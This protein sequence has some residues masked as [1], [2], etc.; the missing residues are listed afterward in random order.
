MI[1]LL[2]LRV[3]FTDL[4][5]YRALDNFFLREPIWHLKF[6]SGSKNTPRNFIAGVSSL[7]VTLE[8]LQILESRFWPGLLL[9]QKTS[10][11]WFMLDLE[12]RINFVLSGW[13]T[14]RFMRKNSHT[15]ANSVFAIFINVSILS[16]DSRSVVSS[17]NNNERNRDDNGKSFTVCIK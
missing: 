16:C 5:A 13:R 4:R 7:Q 11:A 9:L 8:I 6:N 1:K 3:F 17:A 10:T 12:K 2:L 14:R 15:F